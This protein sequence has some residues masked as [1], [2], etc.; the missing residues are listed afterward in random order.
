VDGGCLKS[1]GGI[2]HDSAYG[3]ASGAAILAPGRPPLCYGV[4][5]GRA[6][7]L[8]VNGAPK[9]WRVSA[10]IGDLEGPESIAR[11]GQ[12]PMHGNFPAYLGRAGLE[13]EHD[14]VASDDGEVVTSVS[15]SLGRS[16]PN[17]AM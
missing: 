16:L 3:D 8:L 11:I 7:G 6:Q 13:H 12:F 9:T 5:L 15:V 17:R 14:S 4:L 10:V 1:I 2:L